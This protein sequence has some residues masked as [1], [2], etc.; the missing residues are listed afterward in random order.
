MYEFNNQSLLNNP[1]DYSSSLTAIIYSELFAKMTRNMEIYLSI[2][3]SLL[4]FSIYLYLSIYC[5][6]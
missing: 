3:C 2:I 4:A 5:L 1:S 6:L